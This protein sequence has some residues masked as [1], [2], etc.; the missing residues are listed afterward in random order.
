MERHRKKG[1]LEPLGLPSPFAKASKDRVPD[2]KAGLREGAIGAWAEVREGLKGPIG[3]PWY[4]SKEGV[5]VLSVY[6]DEQGLR[7]G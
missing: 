3:L 7:R 4:W 2:F 6:E 1:P 5:S